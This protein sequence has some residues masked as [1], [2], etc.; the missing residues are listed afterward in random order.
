MKT[1]IKIRN[2]AQALFRESAAYLEVDPRDLYAIYKNVLPT[3]TGKWMFVAHCTKLE[4]TRDTR[5][6]SFEVFL[7]LQPSHDSRFELLYDMM[8]AFVSCH[9]N[10][11][12]SIV[13][14]K[15]NVFCS[16]CDKTMRS[17]SSGYVCPDG[18]GGTEVENNTS[19]QRLALTPDEKNVTLAEL[20][21]EV[22]DNAPPIPLARPSINW[23]SDQDKAFKS[24][25]SWIKTPKSSRNPIYRLFGYAGSGKSSMAKE[26][27][28]N[29][30]HGELGVDFKGKV[31]F[32]AY[33]GKAASVL[34]SK[35]C[36]GAMTIHSLI[37]RPKIDPITGRMIGKTKNDE[38]PL[39]NASLLII[40][41]V[42]MVDEEMAM[43][44]LSF[45]VPI[46]VLGDPKQL[47]PIRGE[48]Y[49]VQSRPDSMLMMV[50]RTALDN[51]LTY[52]ATR[53]RKGLR[54]KPGT[55]GDTIVL[56]RDQAISDQYVMDSHQILVGM[57]NTR[58]TFNK[59]YRMLNGKFDK[60]TVFPVKGDRLMCLKNNKDT[61]VLNGTTWTCTQPKIENIRTL[62]DYR[63]PALGYEETNIEGLYFK[64][65][66]HDMFDLVGDPL[67]VNTVC[68]AHHF[69]VN[70]PPPPWREI[71]GTDHWGFG[72]AS[73]LHK[74]QGSQWDVCLLI[75]ESYVF[76]DQQQEHFYTG[77]TR[78]AQ[79]GYI[80]L[81]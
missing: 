2:A 47:K 74:A 58:D 31:L 43:D 52:L 33:T 14:P 28:W 57:R 73:T 72:Y 30:E 40:D 11:F 48:G 49:F 78:I 3:E 12:F 66:S 26:I 71:A 77:I 68:S 62:I 38:S 51:P 6:G 1:P 9:P 20:F 79:R 50:E 35:G 25:F 42:S 41:E 16:V 17:T 61:G 7:D 36:A 81:G 39:L 32:A 29:V 23:N 5:N 80:K 37:Y 44:L 46:L 13:R 19:I 64:A 65:R 15:S 27:A 63:R 55:Y 53:A 45:G 18:H 54:I 24:V 21:G 22:P 8:K 67:I 59:R 69:D 4:R 75:D 34:R 10:D 76:P 60:D 70:L 56:G